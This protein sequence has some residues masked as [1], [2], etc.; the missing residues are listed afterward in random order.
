MVTSA[1]YFVGL[2]TDAESGQDSRM[3]RFGSACP[4]HAGERVGSEG[5]TCV[6]DCGRPGILLWRPTAEDSYIG[7][8]RRHRI[9][10]PVDRGVPLNHRPIV[11]TQVFT[12]TGVTTRCTYHGAG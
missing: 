4:G 6:V 5:R 10:E 7:T 3:S 9:A 11:L 2:K 8:S 1:T 12:F